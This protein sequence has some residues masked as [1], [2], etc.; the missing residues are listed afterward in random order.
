[1]SVLAFLHNVGD[2]HAGQSP[3][4]FKH[5]FNL[6]RVKLTTVV[7]LKFSCVIAVNM[8]IVSM[9][10]CQKSALNQLVRGYLTNQRMVIRVSCLLFRYGLA[11]FVV[12]V[13][14]TSTKS[15]R[16]SGQTQNT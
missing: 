2:N 14:V 11:V 16:S 4:A 7:K 13:N 12:F 10:R 3:F 6:L 5:F 15:V 1:M 9:W 8:I